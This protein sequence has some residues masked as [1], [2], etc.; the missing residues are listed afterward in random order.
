M[1]ERALAIKEKALGKD[2]PETAVTLF[3]LATTLLMRNV[4]D[5]LI[6]TV[7]LTRL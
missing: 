7:T 5:D 4:D 6:P 1:F 2:H 3:D